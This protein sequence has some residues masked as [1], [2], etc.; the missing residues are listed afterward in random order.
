MFGKAHTDLAGA[1]QTVEWEYEG[2]LCPVGIAGDVETIRCVL[3]RA[4]DRHGQSFWMRSPTA[5]I[6]SCMTRA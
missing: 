6:P 2:H 4:R 1:L 5:I 3:L